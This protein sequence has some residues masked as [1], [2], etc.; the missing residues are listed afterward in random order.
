[1]KKQTIKNLF[2]T[3]LHVTLVS[4]SEE[5]IIEYVTIVE[6]VTETI[7]EVESVE[8]DPFASSTLQ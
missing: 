6:S 1:M 4:C 3:V 7:T 5:P 2:L 8:G